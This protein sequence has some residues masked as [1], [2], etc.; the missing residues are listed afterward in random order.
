[1]AWIAPVDTILT[2]DQSL[3]NAQIVADLCMGWGWDKA[4]ICALCGN[5]RAESWINPNI[6]EFGYGHSLQRGYGLV[7]WTPAT[8][9]MDW[10]AGEGL[11]YTS[12]DTQMARINYE[13]IQNIQWGPKIYG[14]PPYDFR[15]FALNTNNN[16]VAT[17][18]EYFIRFYEAPANLS[19]LPARIAF[20]N[21]CFNELSFSGGGAITIQPLKPVYPETPITSPFG[22]RDIG[23]GTNDHLG[24]DFGGASGDPIFAT[25][26]GTVVRSQYDS[27]RGNYVIIQHSQD[28]YFSTYQ[29]N[30][31]NSVSMGQP[32]KRGDT[33]ALMGTTGDSTGVH[34]H[35]AISTTPYGSY[36][37]DGQVGIFIDPE[38]YLASSI[39]V[40][41]G[42]GGTPDPPSKMP[43]LI[44]L[45]LSQGL[46]GAW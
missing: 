29:H 23:I 35:F 34:L 14:T 22:Y 36:A 8:K 7:Q 24:T 31:S 13:T 43:A 6:W 5:M 40:D 17:L 3:Q 4:S 27:A 19:T 20:A 1:M 46:F 2:E 18:T 38:I 21:R 33:I 39:V 10:A 28:T 44:H 41:G 32:V 42:G 37:D 16:D 15:S 45:L 30:L 9:L 12:G 26:D 25:M 11:D